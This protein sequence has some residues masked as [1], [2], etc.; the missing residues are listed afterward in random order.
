[1][2]PA[3]TEGLVYTHLAEFVWPDLGN[4]QSRHEKLQKDADKNSSI[5]RIRFFESS[6]NVVHMEN[7]RRVV[8]QGLGGYIL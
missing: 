7:A 8:L 1:M 4:W 3:A 6:N 2:Q 5:G